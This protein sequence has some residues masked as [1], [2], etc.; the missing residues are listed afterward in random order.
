MKL[1]LLLP[2]SLL[3]TCCTNID[4][5]NPQHV[6][7]VENSLPLSS[8][9][10]IGLLEEFKESHSIPSTKANSFSEFNV[11]N[12]KTET[13]IF[14]IENQ[15]EKKLFSD[16][17]TTQVDEKSSLLNVEI[18]T[19]EFENNGDKGFAIVTDDER[20]NKVYAYTEN[21]ELADT[22]F[23]IGLKAA[24]HDIKIACEQ[25]LVQF[26]NNKKT[27]TKATTYR[28]IV[29]PITELEWSQ[30]APYN[31]LLL[32]CSGQNW[33]YGG[34][35]P[36]GCTPVA[37]AQAVAYLCPPSVG[38]NISGLRNVGSYADGATTGP[39]VSNMAVWLRYIGS[40]VKASYSCSGTGAW[41]K[42]IKDEFNTWGIKYN[43]EID[44][45]VNIESMA[46]NLYK[47]Y[48]HITTGFTK[49]PREGHTWLWEGI[50]C[51][52]T[53]ISSTTKKV[54]IAA[55]TSVYVYCNWGWGRN[56]CNGW[57]TK[58]NMEMPTNMTK[59]FLDDNEQLYI[60]GTTF[61][62]PAKGQ[63][64]EY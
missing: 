47:G 52:Y 18:H 16:A 23:N 42:E 14:D 53:S 19:V 49:K 8:K 60:T 43:L 22:T 13:Y 29:Q 7:E 20:I 6:R 38:Y 10:T 64:V 35:A 15:L 17:E 4:E 54:T 21:G 37:I 9:K 45:N 32:T 12:I 48:P 33:Q 39:W 27:M 34:R 30:R 55:N 44:V 24:L 2:V 28:L 40:C 31:Q 41:L 36:A 57:Y 46:Y 25:D 63:I 5:N 51:R 3:L 50:D 56:S 59:P 1:Y 26:Y 11:T 61:T 62:I 58:A